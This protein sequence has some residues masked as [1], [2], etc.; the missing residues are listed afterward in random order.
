MEKF[1][2]NCEHCGLPIGE[3]PTDAPGDELLCNDCKK[4]YDCGLNN[5]TICAPHRK[6]EV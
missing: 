3:V 5:C 2:A 6:E 1:S 4:D